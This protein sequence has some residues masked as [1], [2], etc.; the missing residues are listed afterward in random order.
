MKR[1]TFDPSKA[2]LLRA[3]PHS[4]LIEI[5]GEQVYCF[6]RLWNRIAND[7]CAEVFIE[8]T[9]RGNWLAVLSRF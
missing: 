8:E 6:W 5:N 9:E 4:V 7:P 2:R 1:I 3:N